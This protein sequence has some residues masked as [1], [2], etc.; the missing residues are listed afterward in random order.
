VCSSQ[1]VAQLN[2]NGASLRFGAFWS[3]GKKVLLFLAD[4]DLED[5]MLPPQFKGNLRVNTAQDLITAIKATTEQYTLGLAQAKGDTPYQFF[6]TS[7][8]YGTETDWK[9]LLEKTQ[10]R[11][12]LLG[13][14][15][16]SWRRTPGFSN[17]ALAK[18]KANC[19]IR[20]LLMHQDNSL[21]TGLLLCHDQK[22][23][24][25]RSDIEGNFQFY[26]DLA[27]K[28]ATR[29]IEV[30][31]IC[32]GISHFFLT[33]SDHYAIMIQYQSSQEWG[34]GPF[35]E[36]SRSVQTLQFCREGV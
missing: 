1:R 17:L 3:A 31:Q 10:S 14:T 29:N 6:E 25:V 30:R 19:R 26:Q 16:G 35:V 4:P 8:N 34:S 13:V 22:F 2:L 15:L 32:N 21:L 28:D 20:I 36:N 27:A 11:F 9:E 33:I 12:D 5:S 23:D 18:A 24:S 7:G